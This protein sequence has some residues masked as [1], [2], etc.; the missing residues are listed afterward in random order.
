MISRSSEVDGEDRGEER[1]KGGFL[2]LIKHDGKALDVRREAATEQSMVASGL[3][4]KYESSLS[5]GTKRTMGD[6][7]SSR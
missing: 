2:Y 6:Q 4:N 1:G 7:R 3:S 5:M